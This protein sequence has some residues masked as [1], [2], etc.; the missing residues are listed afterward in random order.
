MSL[1]FI[2]YQEAALP[3]ANLLVES[4][5]QTLRPIVIIAMA[6]GVVCLLVA[7]VFLTDSTP[8][9]LSETLTPGNPSTPQAPIERGA[10]GRRF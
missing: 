6:V 8:K 9:S 2:G 10:P 7:N 5:P 4:I 1:A 3:L